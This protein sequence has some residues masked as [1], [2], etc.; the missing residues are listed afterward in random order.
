MRWLV[1]LV[2]IYL[3]THL[4]SWGSWFCTNSRKNYTYPFTLPKTIY[5]DINVNWFG[6]ILLY[7]LYL[8][9]VP[10][11]AIGTFIYWLCTVGR[12]NND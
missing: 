12:N 1:G 4:I 10:I 7:C 8:T 11:F 9:I 3:I 6:A 5:N 2:I